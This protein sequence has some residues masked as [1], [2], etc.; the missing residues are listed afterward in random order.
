MIALETAHGPLR[1]PAYFP[2]ATY[3]VVRA[4]DSADLEAARVGGLVVNALHLAQKPGMTVIASAGGIHRFMGWNR[5][6]ASDS[7][8]F[9]A[10]SLIS[11]SKSMGRITDDGFAVRAAQGGKQ[12][13][14]TPEK[15]IENQFKLGADIMMCLDQCTHPASAEK[16]QE[17]SVRRTLIWARLCRK[18]FDAMCRAL[19]EGSPRPL[20]FAIVQ[21]G[22]SAELRRRCAGELVGIGFDGYGFGGWPVNDAG[23]PE[24][25][26]ELTASLLPPEAP[27]F[28]LG[29]GSPENIAAAYRAGYRIFDCTMPTRDARHAR[30]YTSLNLDA[31]P[32][33]SI[34]RTLNARAER[35]VRQDSPPDPGCDCLT[36]RRYSLAY[37]R[38]LFF[39][40][41]HM[42]CRLATIH[43]LRFYTRLL[44]ALS[45]SGD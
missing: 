16:V 7:G 18:T 22:R 12:N 20:L 36:C 25:S 17:E 30:L 40:E 15:C 1:L 19:P 31:R 21:G 11:R 38:H 39:A 28:G 44:E 14:L 9:Q 4:V 23:K 3:G 24:E 5:P 41:E 13:S 45:A 2:D 43:N 33:E 8:G 26:V 34:C 27:K 37:L 29:I 10:Y 6:I 35:M 42:A 32:G